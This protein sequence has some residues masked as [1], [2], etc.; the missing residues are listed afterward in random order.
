VPSLLRGF[1]APVV[2]E[3]EESD[4]RLAFRMAHDS[5]PFNRWDA[6]QRYAERV[7]LT[8]AS[9]LTE[10]VEPRVPEGFIAAFRALLMNEAL[11]P[12][13]RALAASLP[14]EAYLLERM[15]PADPGV[16]RK[17]LVHL[18][19]ELGRGS[20][21]NGSICTSRSRSTAPTDTIPPMR[22]GVRSE[23]SHC[24][25]WSVPTSR[26]GWR[27]PRRSASMRRT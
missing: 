27:A 25:T 7:V 24:G 8:L 17:A 20:R 16:L 2:L 26:M 10:G 1:S 23:T 6:A 18:M 4:E 13:F 9:D 12:G 3:L 21:M 22:G 15:K 5:D 14:G 19:A 11:D